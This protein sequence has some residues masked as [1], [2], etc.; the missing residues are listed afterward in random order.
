MAD[1]ADGFET[2]FRGY[3]LDRV[4]A[5]GRHSVEVIGARCL[6]G[7]IEDFISKRRLLELADCP[8][9]YGGAAGKA[10][11]VNAGETGF[12]FVAAPPVTQPV[13]ARPY[14]TEEALG[15]QVVSDDVLVTLLTMSRLAAELEGGETYLGLFSVDSENNSGA[16]LMGVE[17]LVDGV[18]V[19]A[20]DFVC[21]TNAPNERLGFSG[22]F[23]FEP[24][25]TPAATDF[26]IK[27]SGH[28]GTTTTFT[29]ARLSILKLG[30]GDFT[31]ED[32]AGDSTTSTSLTTIDT[33]NFTPASE[34]D[35]VVLGYFEITS[36][37]ITTSVFAE[38]SDGATTTG[39][40]NP[41]PISASGTIYVEQCVALAISDASGAQSVT[42]KGRTANASFAASF[43]NIRWAAIRCDR[44]ANVYRTRLASESS[45]TATTYTTALSQ[46]F[47]P[48]AGDHLTI[49]AY[50]SFNSSAT[51]SAYSRFVDG[52]TTVNEQIEDMGRNNEGFGVMPTMS[53]RI[54]AFVPSTR[55]QSIDRKAEANTAGIRAGAM[56]VAF[57]LNGIM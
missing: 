47:S 17:V 54:A 35:Y 37:A 22:I 9:G 14:Y 43:R 42:L 56:I 52:G 31:R 10:L 46:T 6:G 33:F 39:P 15:A 40:N 48:V 1:I 30:P 18:T 25:V 24:G 38:V 49:A 51:S 4:P 34:G 16:G 45:S 19:Y 55:T 44:F 27:G 41:G 5:S 12:E 26:V 7:L 20:R 28:G 53:H 36:A 2:V 11:A 23:F 13:T 3:E 57:D 21:A 50:G 8:T 32:L 29:N